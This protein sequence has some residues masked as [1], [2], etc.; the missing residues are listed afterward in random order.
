MLFSHQK[1]EVSIH[2]AVKMNL[3]NIMLNERI[4]IQK[5]TYCIIPFILNIYN[6]Q[7]HRDPR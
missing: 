2:A 4:Q 1:D 5:T 7:I 6:R 3:G